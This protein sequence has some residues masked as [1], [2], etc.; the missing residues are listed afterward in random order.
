VIY[1]LIHTELLPIETIQNISLKYV[2]KNP[3]KQ[4]ETPMGA[5]F[6]HNT[7]PT[8]TIKNFPT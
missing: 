2:Q 3:F 6:F 4:L 8:N 5:D 7:T 1:A